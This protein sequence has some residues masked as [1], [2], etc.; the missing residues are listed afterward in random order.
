MLWT[1]ENLWEGDGDSDIPFA[2]MCVRHNF[3]VVSRAEK[4]IVFEFQTVKNI[5]IG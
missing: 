5:L 3:W 1:Q 2:S 4:H